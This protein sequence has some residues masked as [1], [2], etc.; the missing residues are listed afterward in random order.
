MKT[1]IKATII[2]LAVILGIVLYE[3][4][5]DAQRAEYAQTHNCTWTIYGS[6]DICK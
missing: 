2:I 3:Q 6:H 5:K 1:K 4:H